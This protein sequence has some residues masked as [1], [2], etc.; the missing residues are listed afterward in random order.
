M[1]FY[2]QGITLKW[3]PFSSL[4]YPTCKQEVGKTPHGPTSS[5]PGFYE[6]PVSS[7]LSHPWLCHSST[8]PG[9]WCVPGMPRPGPHFSL[10]LLTQQM[11]FF[12]FHFTADVFTATRGFVQGV[13]WTVPH[14]AVCGKKNS[15]AERG[16]FIQ[17]ECWGL[18]LL[19]EHLWDLTCLSWHLV[20]L[21]PGFVHPRLESTKGILSPVVLCTF[22]LLVGFPHS[23]LPDTLSHVIGVRPGPWCSLK[24]PQ[25]IQ[26]YSW[27]EG[28]QVT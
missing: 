18:R 12:F 15:K 19:P 2:N 24:A 27:G 4:R 28:T 7:Y 8:G 16:G 9:G 11:S 25:V 26:R 22:E 6:M 21:I 23:L 3:L 1:Y 14:D 17:Q 5:D 10:S 13:S 20:S